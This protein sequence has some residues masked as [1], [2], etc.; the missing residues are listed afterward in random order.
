MSDAILVVG[1]GSIG[2][3]HLRCF[4]KTGRASVAAGDANTALLQRI[5]RQ[6]GVSGHPNLEAALNAARFDGIVICTPAHTH[7][8]LA[9]AALKHGAAVLIE[10]PLSVSLEEVDALQDAMAKTRKFVGVAY[11]Y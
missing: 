7:I 10:K 6:Y 1:C 11:I 5:T 3:R 2:E 8:H 9:L 4:Q